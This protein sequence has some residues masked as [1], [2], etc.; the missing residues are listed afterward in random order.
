MTPSPTYTF[1]PTYSLTYCKYIYACHAQWYNG[2]WRGGVGS[3]DLYGR[4]DGDRG[5]LGRGG[6]GGPAPYQDA[7]RREARFVS[8]CGVYM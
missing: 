1:T 2:D 4:L 3:G 7:A 8:A 5:D 6:R